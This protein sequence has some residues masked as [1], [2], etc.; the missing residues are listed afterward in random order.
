MNWSTVEV[1]HFSFNLMGYWL[2]F[3]AQF[4]TEH[5][6]Y[7]VY[8]DLQ[9]IVCLDRE[10]RLWFSFLLVEIWSAEH[11]SGVLYCCIMWKCPHIL[12]SF[13]SLSV[14]AM[15][16]VV[17]RPASPSPSIS[18][19]EIKAE[20]RLVLKSFLRHSLSIPPG[21]RPGRIGG[22]YNDPNKYRWHKSFKLIQN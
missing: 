7:K 16:H 5:Y 4:L 19:L 22:E 13:S 1:T 6:T 21:E 2:Y 15:A 12:K 8:I 17:V 20:T 11:W 10:L 3:N 18:L 9:L 14:S